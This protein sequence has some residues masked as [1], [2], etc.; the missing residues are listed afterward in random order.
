MKKYV[1]MARKGVQIFLMESLVHS[2]KGSCETFR[3]PSP[4][5]KLHTE[6]IALACTVKGTRL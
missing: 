1:R 3:Y 6:L 4:L 5:F 2:L